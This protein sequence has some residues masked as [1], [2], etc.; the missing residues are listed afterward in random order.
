LERS[1]TPAI[2]GFAIYRQDIERLMTPRLSPWLFLLLFAS[3]F[4]ESAF[5]GIN[6]ALYDLQYVI[7]C[8]SLRTQLPQ[9]LE[10]A[11][12]LCDYWQYFLNNPPS[13]R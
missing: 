1:E 7:S 3:L 2:N 12:A 8:L 13:E 9:S 10:R 5:T 4:G 6:T 11:K